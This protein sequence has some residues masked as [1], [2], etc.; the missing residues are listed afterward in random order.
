MHFPLFATF[1]LL[2]LHQQSSLTDSRGQLV[3]SARQKALKL[4][5]EITFFSD[6]QQT[7][8]TLLIKADRIL[9]F[10]ASYKL[11]TTDGRV[12][13]HLQ[14]SGMSSFWKAHFTIRAPDGQLITISEANPWIKLLDSILGGLP[15]IGPLSS[16]FLHPTYHVTSNRAGIL[17][18]FT[19]LPAFW[20]GRFKIE[21]V[22]T[23]N[24]A[25]ES[26]CV[27]C[28]MMVLILE[29]WRG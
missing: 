9:D 15:I 28:I 26:L 23:S 24:E 11:S 3:F 19:K 13:G 18:R 17:M 7:V 22:I 21:R 25:T 27:S 4:R 14:R 12:M 8:P 2:T 5:E 10:G 29:R 20:E 16:Y 6:R 1:K